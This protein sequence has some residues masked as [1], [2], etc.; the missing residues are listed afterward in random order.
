MLILITGIPGSGKTT[1]GNYLRDERGYLHVDVE[2]L[3]QGA[4]PGT[5]WAT[6][7]ASPRRFGRI[8]VSSQEGLRFSDCDEVREIPGKNPLFPTH[9]PAFT[10]I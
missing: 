6:I 8:R 1:I 9:A 4:P 10:E 2:A 3:I 7:L 5:Q